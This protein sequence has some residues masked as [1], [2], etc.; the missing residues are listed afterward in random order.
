MTRRAEEAWLIGYDVRDPRRLSR[1]HR[2]LKGHAIPVQYSVFVF[3]GTPGRFAEVLQGIRERIH[4]GRDDVR[5]Y[6]LGAR[7][8]VWALGRQGFPEGVILGGSDIAQLLRREP[9]PGSGM[10]GIGNL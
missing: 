9:V 5:C 10:D 3:L 7:C 6:H 4:P 2:W 1:L 8:P